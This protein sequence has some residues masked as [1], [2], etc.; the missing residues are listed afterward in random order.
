MQ[1]CT[2]GCHCGK[3]RFEIEIPKSI[4]VHRCSCSICQKSGYLH[5]IVP[6][7]RFNLLCGQESLLD[8]R[9]HTRVARHLFCGHCG[10]K[11]FYVP[12]SHPDSFSVN[13][14]CVDLPEVVEVK[15]KDFDGRNWSKNRGQIS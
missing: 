12:R 15:I 11:S 14:N 2:G 7:D 13:L 5:L 1:T 6:A 9:F 10:I 3:V 8:Y 4:T